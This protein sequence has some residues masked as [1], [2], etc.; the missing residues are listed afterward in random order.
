MSIIK[1]KW[2]F[3]RR[4]QSHIAS[5]RSSMEIDQL[6]GALPSKICECV[7][8]QDERTKDYAKLFEQKLVERDQVQAEQKESAKVLKEAQTRLFAKLPNHIPVKEIS[9]K[10]RK[11][12]YAKVS[13]F[14][15]HAKQL[16]DDLASFRE[17]F[18]GPTDV[19]GTVHDVKDV[20]S[21]AQFLLKDLSQSITP[22]FV[23]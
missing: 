13:T 21:V 15:D 6:L 2:E 16:Q 9:S 4:M 7:R 17:R 22:D 8:L 3:Y 11:E 23:A 18:D 12:L 1:D 10:E 19:D 14:F 20:L 5:M